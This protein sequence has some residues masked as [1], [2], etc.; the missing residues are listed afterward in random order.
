MFCLLSRIERVSQAS[1]RMVQGLTTVA[2]STSPL[3]D[4]ASVDNFLT[5]AA[6]EIVPLFEQ[7]DFEFLLE[8]DVFSP[9]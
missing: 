2:S 8:K 6:T 5:V 1:Q 3:Q 4:V 7:F 9:A